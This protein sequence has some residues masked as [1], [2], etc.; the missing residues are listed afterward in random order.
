MDRLLRVAAIATG[1]LAL[2]GAG[3]ASHQ[4]ARSAE[5]L[6]AAIVREDGVVVPFAEYRGDTWMLPGVE[7]TNRATPRVNTP[8][9]APTTWAFPSIESAGVITTTDATM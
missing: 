3:L 4:A 9:P 8:E 7:L 1:L 5:R 2:S 6:L